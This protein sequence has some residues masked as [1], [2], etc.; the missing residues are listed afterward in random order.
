MFLLK[1]TIKNTFQNTPNS[2]SRKWTLMTNLSPPTGFG[3]CTYYRNSWT[4]QHIREIPKVQKSGEIARSVHIWYTTVTTR[5]FCDTSLTN[6]K[7]GCVIFVTRTALCHNAWMVDQIKKIFK[8]YLKVH[9]GSFPTV[10]Q[11]IQ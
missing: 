4:I 8:M 7:Q 10:Y 5:E 6:H 1:N 11:M 3:L 9:K 2:R